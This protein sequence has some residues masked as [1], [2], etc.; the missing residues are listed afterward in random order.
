MFLLYNDCIVYVNMMEF[1]LFVSAAN[2][3]IL[4]W[5]CCWCLN[6][7]SW[8]AYWLCCIW[9]YFETSKV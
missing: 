1:L 6:T 8:L 5:L 7:E 9:N 4:I 2:H 3:Q